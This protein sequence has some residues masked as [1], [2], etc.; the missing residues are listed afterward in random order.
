M[1]KNIFSKGLQ[2]IIGQ[3]RYRPTLSS[4][5]NVPV[6][7]GELEK[8]FE[9]WQASK[10]DDVVLYSPSKKK[11]LQVTSDVITYVN[12]IETDTDE[13]IKYLR[14]VFE[15]NIKSSAVRE[16]RRIGVRNTQILKCAFSY[17][18]IV[19]LFYRKFYSQ[20]KKLKSISVDTPRDV[21]FVLDGVK[22]DFWNHVQIG[23]VKK[24]EAINS[25]KATIEADS[26][27]ITGES[28]LFIDVD[29]FQSKNLS[30]ENAIEKIQQAIKENLK[31]VKE[32]IDFLNP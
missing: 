8:E 11:Y 29:V 9:E 22:N 17:Q 23:P 1:V 16:V 18:E 10:H 21:V 7:A 32:Y 6:I 24:Q 4:F 30:A 19:D 15:K 5:D 27:V 25:F 2:R 31:I 14:K 26:K 13:L 20:E 12:E 3:I 28:N